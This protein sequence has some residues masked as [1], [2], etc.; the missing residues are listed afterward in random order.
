MDVA[1]ST[2]EWS[3]YNTA[4]CFYPIQ[5]YEYTHKTKYPAF[6]FFCMASSTYPIFLQL[7]QVFPRVAIEFKIFNI[8][9]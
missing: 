4:K 9:K 6:K 8:C 1:I 2:K 3:R 7:S 5:N